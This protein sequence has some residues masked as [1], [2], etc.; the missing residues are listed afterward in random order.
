M[1]K[2]SILL[3]ALSSTYFVHGQNTTS[4]NCTYNHLAL[5]VKDVDQSIAFYKK[6]L[7]LKEITNRTKIEGIRLPE[8]G[9]IIVYS[10]CLFIQRKSAIACDISFG[11]NF[12]INWLFGGVYECNKI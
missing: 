2:I 8:S 6:I 12:I 10:K 1:K 5:S 11:N 3:I 7:N 4:F 9:S